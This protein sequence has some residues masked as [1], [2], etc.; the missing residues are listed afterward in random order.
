[1]DV[2]QLTKPAP[3]AF[4]DLSH[5]LVY[6]SALASFNCETFSTHRKRN[7]GRAFIIAGIGGLLVPLTSGGYLL[8]D[9]IQAAHA[10]GLRVH[11]WVNVL[12]LAQNRD[13]PLLRQL[14]RSAVLV[15]TEDPLR[16]L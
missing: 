14:G 10:A 2:D 13:A 16:V 7:P 12:S 5:A 11:A 3:I 4:D 1:M 9:L 15:A 8:A 6:G